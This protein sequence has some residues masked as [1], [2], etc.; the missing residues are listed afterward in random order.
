[1]T[2]QELQMATEKMIEKMIKT[3]SRAN[4][5][6]FIAGIFSTVYGLTFLFILPGVEAIIL[7]SIITAFG[8]LVIAFSIT[9][10][11]ATKKDAHVKKKNNFNLR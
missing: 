3:R 11:L 6:T 2:N 10:R 8:L 4:V 7:G 9:S 1:M 5:F